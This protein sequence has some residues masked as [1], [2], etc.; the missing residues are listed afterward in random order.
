[1]GPFENKVALITG[2]ASGIGRCVSHTWAKGGAHV[3]VAD[4]NLEGAQET[5]AQIEAAGGKAEAVTLDVTD[6]EAF[7][8]LVK[9]TAKR[10]GRLDY[11]F[12]NA[13]IAIVGEIHELS[14]DHWK[15]IID[16]DLWGVIYG[17]LAAYEVMREQGF[18]HIINTASGYGLV[19]GG[20]N[21]PYITAKW[22]VVGFSEALRVEAHG[23]GISVSTVCPGFVMTPILTDSETI[24]VNITEVLKKSPVGAITPEKAAE[25]ILAGVQAGDAIIAFPFYVKILTWLYRLVPGIFFRENLKQLAMM[26]RIGDG[27]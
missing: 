12:N 18:G 27:K 8:T 21:A 23:F 22:G 7:A 11:Q 3:I 13:G 10:L 25:R 6:G 17:S 19:A 14:L 15:K 4:I 26:R 1:M 5:V 24:G 2:G 9:D 16:I 20:S